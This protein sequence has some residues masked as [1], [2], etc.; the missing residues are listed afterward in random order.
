[1]RL[2]LTCAPKDAH[3]STSRKTVQLK[4][5]GSPSVKASVTALWGSRGL[6]NVVDLDLSFDVQTE[7]NVLRRLDQERCFHLSLLGSAALNTAY[8]QCQR[9]TSDSSRT[10]FKVCCRSRPYRK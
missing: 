10:Y 9:Y 2:L 1:M 8:F 5:D 6:D 7:K 4:T 3:D